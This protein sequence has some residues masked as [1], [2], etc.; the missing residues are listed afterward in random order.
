MGQIGFTSGQISSSL[1]QPRR[2]FA[3]QGQPHARLGLTVAI[4]RM[5]R[6][7][8][9]FHVCQR[10]AS[11]A[12]MP[13]GHKLR[14]RI[15]VNVVPA[16][17]IAGDFRQHAGFFIKPYGGLAKARVGGGLCDGHGLSPMCVWSC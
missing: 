7:G 6:L 2:A 12:Q 3:Q 13:Q 1:G 9:A 15:A 4:R 17:G 14:Q 11:A 10:H 16:L 5:G 8:K